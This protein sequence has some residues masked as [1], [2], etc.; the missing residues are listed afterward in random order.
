MKTARLLVVVLL[1][2][3]SSARAAV[4]LELDASKLPVGEITETGNVIPGGPWHPNGPLRVEKVEG[5]TA[6]VFGGAEQLISEALPAQKWTDFTVEAWVMNPTLERV[7]TVADITGVVGGAGA[8]FNFASSANS[9]AFR[10]GFKATTPFTALPAAGVWHHLAWTYAG[11][12]LRVFVD[13]ELDLERPL[14]VAPASPAKVHLGASG[15]V[16][17]KG[18]KQA[19]KGAIARWRLHDTALTQSELRASAGLVGP[20][21]PTP[22]DGSTT[23][24][25]EIVP[26]WRSDSS[27]HSVNTI[28]LGL[29]RAAV[30]RGDAATRNTSALVRLRAGATYFWR[31]QERNAG[32]WQSSP[33]WTF[34]ADPGLAADPRPRDG[35]S[36][37]PTDLRNLVWRPGRYAKTQRVF[38]GATREEV[39][40]A[41][42]PVAEFPANIGG[43]PV[44]GP[45]APGTLVYWRVESD[46][47]EQPRSPGHVWTF[48]TQDAP[49][50]D[51]VTFF[52][53]SDTHYGRENNAAINRRVIDAMNA[54]PG[55]SLPAS[56]G[57]GVV[58]TPRGVVL[59]GDLLDEGFDK[60]SA[61]QNWV[62][63]CRDYGL[64]GRDGRLC[65]PL[66]EGFGNHDGGPAKSFVRAGIKERN[67]KRI[68]L[69]EISPDGHHYSWDWDHVHLVQLNLFG[70]SGPEDVKGVNAAEH[71]PEGALEFLRADLAK[72]VA[73][74]GRPVII[75]QHFAWVGGMADWWQ[76]EAKERFYE[77]VKPYRVACLINGHSH[78]ASF[79]PWKDL[80]TVHDGSTA[81]GESDTGDFMVVRVTAS[82]L[83]LAQRKLDGTWGITMRRPLTR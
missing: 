74:S 70:G 1:L 83:I 39:E 17:N 22:R 55:Q 33:V 77:V 68:G 47:G 11:G 80:L 16:D 53:S 72:H 2:V 61:P 13:G 35:T 67:P 41:T 57:G 81:R 6:L 14:K 59:N 38:I 62:E 26:L 48:R 54:L 15:E 9:G 52:V 40:R 66:Y 58:R 60:E 75:F 43:C 78:G 46:N 51:D 71:N 7:E 20:Y 44:P 8:E 64:T 63:F 45:L 76:M 50:Q 30:A 37:A 49:V 4:L 42:Q 5:R 12:V 3:I 28:F 10:S 31:V 25:L 18:P 23:E 69:A 56:A 29:D 19:F 32:K 21:A 34:T 27:D 73:T 24:A 36:N 65:F 79:A 82:E